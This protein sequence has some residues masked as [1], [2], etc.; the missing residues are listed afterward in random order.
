MGVFGLRPV[1]AAGAAEARDRLET[2]TRIAADEGL[3]EAILDP[4]DLT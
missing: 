3:S 1:V 2:L 4:F